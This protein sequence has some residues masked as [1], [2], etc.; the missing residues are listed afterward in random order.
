[1][2]TRPNKQ[3]WNFVQT[4]NPHAFFV[5]RRCENSLAVP[6]SS[7]EDVRALFAKYGSERQLSIRTFAITKYVNVN[8]RS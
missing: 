8:I 1:M 6:Y 5:T 7:D 2:Q 3:D 4:E